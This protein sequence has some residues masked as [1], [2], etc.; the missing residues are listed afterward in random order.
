MLF[1]SGAVLDDPQVRHNGQLVEI[2]HGELGRV[3][4]ARAA[5]RFNGQPMPPPKPAAHLGEHG[6]AV[7]QELGLDPQQ[8]ERLVADGVLRLP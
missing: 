2:E 1:R 6:M 3:R 7:L 8:I 5:A 4:L